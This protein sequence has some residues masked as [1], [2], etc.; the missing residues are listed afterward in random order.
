MVTVAP[1]YAMV[2]KLICFIIK[3]FLDE[4]DTAGQDPALQLSVPRPLPKI[5]SSF[6][7]SI[8]F[9]FLYWVI[10]GLISNCYNLMPFVFLSLHLNRPASIAT[11]HPLNQRR[12]GVRKK[13]FHS[14]V[15][16]PAEE[17]AHIC[18]PWS[19]G[20]ESTASATG[21]VSK[22]ISFY[23]CRYRNPG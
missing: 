12:S 13:D 5:F 23:I 8:F 16:D 18:Q 14:W 20:A 10:Q 4:Y 7:H 22:Q 21:N 11:V 3:T 17:S 1:S 19:T 6:C 2:K 9:A 15:Y